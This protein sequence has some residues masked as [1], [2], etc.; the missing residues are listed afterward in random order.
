MKSGSLPGTGTPRFRWLAIAGIIGAF[1]A[2][3]YA[4]VADL[5]LLHWDDI[6]FVLH[7]PHL[8]DVGW[9]DVLW[10]FAGQRGGNWQPITWMSHALDFMVFGDGTRGP[11]V[12]NAVLHGIAAVLFGW[13]AAT[14]IATGFDRR[15]S[16]SLS[17]F[18]A[19]GGA[20][21][22]LLFAVHPQHVEVVAWVSERKELLCAL[23]YL[24]AVA[25]YLRYSASRRA[26]WRWTAVAANALALLAKPMAVSLPVALL[27]L[28]AFPLRRLDRRTWRTCL[29]EKWPHIMLSAAVVPVAVWSQ[30][31]AG[32]LSGLDTVGLLQRVLNAAHSLVLYPAK[33]LLPINLVP[34]YPHPDIAGGATLPGLWPVVACVLALSVAGLFWRRGSRAPAVVL[35][36]YVVTAL[37]VLGLVQFGSHAAADR[38]AYLP[39]LPAYVLLG[40][41]VTALTNQKSRVLQAVTA[42]G[43]IAL[44][45]GLG[46]FTRTLVPVWA[47]DLTLWSYTVARVPE[48]SLPR[49]NLGNSL[50]EEGSYAAAARQ[51][52]TALQN[53]AE[54]ATA[55]RNLALTYAR[56]GREKEAVSQYTRFLHSH[57]NASEVRI[58]MG[59]LLCRMQDWDEAARA[60]E[61]AIAIAPENADAYYGMA[62]VRAARGDAAAAIGFA[63]RALELDPAHAGARAVLARISETG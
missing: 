7:N 23:F 12:V 61:R 53:D 32:A 44:A 14:L 3:A 59:M 36:W 39:T 11:H 54:H 63:R 10:M 40:A 50:F 47:S 27:L 33:L 52:E 56:L 17:I 21:A 16:G 30:G 8:Q 51:Y 25:A 48:A 15:R 58:E 19:A 26:G 34:F 22:G 1:T 42:A 29:I 13:I 57:P 18:D 43:V 24:S 4:G 35:A 55:R 41:G 6:P 38:Y 49:V 37:P 46:Q 28:D 62:I 31:S 60:F 5:G 9:S 45:T 2:W 20:V